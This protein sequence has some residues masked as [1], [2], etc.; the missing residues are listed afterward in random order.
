[1]LLGAAR[2]TRAGGVPIAWYG[3]AIALSLL[4]GWLV[5]VLGSRY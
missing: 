5:V 2:S 1:M 3:L 4:M